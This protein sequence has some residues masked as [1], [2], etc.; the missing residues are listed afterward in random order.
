VLASLVREEVLAPVDAGVSAM[1]AAIAARYG[2]AARAVLFYGSCLRENVL[3]G[4]VLDF[5]V[6]VSDYRAAYRA[7]WLTL[8]NRLLPP[9]VFPFQHNGLS[10]KYAVLSEADFRRGCGLAAPEVGVWARF[11]QP[12]RVAWS[13]DPAATEMVVECLADAITTLFSYTRP[14]IAAAAADDM[15]APWRQGLALTYSCELRT[16]RVGRCAAIVASDPERY[17]R[18][19]AA[20]RAESLASFS[21][22]ETDAIWRRFRRRGK[23]MTVARLFKGAMTFSG[24]VDYLAWKINRHTGVEIKAW[25]RRWPVFGAIALLPRLLKRGA[26]R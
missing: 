3:D 13:S 17:R 16:E 1:A 24:G 7:G 23:V 14:R 12:S 5:Y 10:A 11:S 2:A 21:A 6:I 26:I 18:F 19:A 20:A 9:N 8:A 22:A 25:H 15:L 4:M